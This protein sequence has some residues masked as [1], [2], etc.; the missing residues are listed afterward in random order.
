MRPNNDR[1]TCLPCG[2]APAARTQ[3]GAFTLI[4]L[5]VVIAIIAILAAMLLPVLGKA[6]EKAKRIGCLNNLKQ[7]GLGSVMYA[8]DSNGDL[9]GDSTT[10]AGVTTPGYRDGTDDDVNFLYPGYVSSLQSFVCPSTQNVV[11]NGTKVIG[12]RT[13]VADLRGNCPDGKNKIATRWDGHGTSYEVFGTFQDARGINTKKTEK[14]LFAYTIASTIG[15]V[16]LKPG[17]TRV[18][19]Y[20]DADEGTSAPFGSSLPPWNNYPDVT[21]NHGASGANVSFCDGHAAWMNT[22]AYLESYNISMDSNVIK[23]DKAP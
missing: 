10:D 17:P 23:P 1:S 2:T 20:L 18:W 12:G 9:V 7:M 19:L 22:R 3:R 4:E 5:L 6:K 8:D 15:S 16:G 11:T 14:R 21:D 13:F